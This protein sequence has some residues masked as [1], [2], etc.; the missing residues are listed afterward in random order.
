MNSTNS[1]SSPTPYNIAQSL[2]EMTERAP[3]RRAIVF[4]AGRDKQGRAK[5]F[6][7]TFAQLNQ[8][9]DSYAHGLREYGLK[10]GDR[11]LLMVKPGV[12]L[13]AVAFALFK[14]GA[15]PILID[16]GMGR[17]PFLQCVAETEPVAF[18]GIPLAHALRTLFPKA[19]R[20]VQKNITAGK[21]W[22]WGGATL[23]ELQLSRPEPAP[24][25]PTT[26]ESEAAVAFT[27]GSTGIPKG[28]VYLHGMFQAQIELLKVLGV[29]DGEV[30]MPGLPIFALFNPALGV[31]TIMPDMDFR[32]P[33]A[34]NPAYW[35]ESIQTHGVTTSFGSPTI[36]KIVGQYCLDNQIKLPSLKRIFMAG[37]PVPP[38]LIQEYTDHIL[39]GGH[40]HTP[41]GATEA[42]P[43]STIASTEILAE[44]AKLTD[45]GWG[46]CVGQP[47]DGVTIQIIPIS[48]EPIADWH[49]SLVLP[50]GELGEIAVKGPV[51]TR[52][53]LNRPEQ[54]AQAKIR[55]GDAVWHR[56]GDLGY[57]DKRG[58]L[59][60]CGRK[61]HRVQTAEELLLPV[62]CEAIFNA[63]PDVSRTALVG[64][65]PLGSQRPVL[66][67]EL[68][69]GALPDGSTQ[70]RLIDELLAQGQ[71]Y[72]HTQGIKDF[73]FK[74]SF[75]VDVRHN[76]KIQR[77]K[78]AV[79][80]AK[81]L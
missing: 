61:A 39:D 55:E 14:I 49:D 74:E 36:W 26:T 18:I 70:Q 75:P 65:G 4:P 73:L 53:Y 8:L 10:Q 25:A 60:M 5:N 63:H 48:D 40:I 54:T 33:A 62:P 80:A 68:N 30:D 66:I 79:W 24:F 51:V 50:P 47:L 28:V 72:E 77:E 9:V 43:I 16:P 3:F 11:T 38:W 20:T 41:F 12:E 15:V 29:G 19:F 23:A 17:K 45:E 46:V 42:L 76:V 7:L 34:L 13:I 81:Q 44:T 57:F 69:S 59:W 52:L 58:R 35:V 31:T 6:Q 56:M 71:K 27:S 2:A 1:P 22:F 32:K 21:R 64:V 67:V 37:A 78:L